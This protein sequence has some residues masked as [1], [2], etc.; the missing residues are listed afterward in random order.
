MTIFGN[1]SASLLGF[2]RKLHGGSQPI[3]AQASDG[4]DYVV[5][6]VNNPQGQNLL[7]NEAMGSELFRACGLAVP[8]W[9]PLLVSDAFLDQN[10]GCWMESP[11][12]HLR[13]APGLCYGS[14]F[15]GGPETQLL[16]ILP[17]S[18]FG[19]VC[20]RNAFWF[21]WLID[22]CADHADNRQAIFVEDAL[23]TLHATFVDHGHMF[24][25]S[26][27]EQ[28]KPFIASRYL[29]KRIYP[30]VVWE[31]LRNFQEVVGS[32]DVDLLW[33]RAQ[34]LPEEWTELSALHRFGEC[35]DRLATP[36]FLQQTLVTMVGITGNDNQ[37]RCTDTAEGRKQPVPVLPSGVQPA[38]SGRLATSRAV[39]FPACA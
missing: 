4:V 35:L 37:P 9:K 5:K 13:P 15:L 8:K 31:Q 34:H 38:I 14:R 32:L 16:E 1:D 22:I 39:C 25:G 11:T 29:D 27:G 21:A 24:G 2:V 12:G 23:K 17:G 36:S 26:K 20:N 6:F 19:R 33:Q 3:L 7:F 10:P 18:S 28:Y 30:D